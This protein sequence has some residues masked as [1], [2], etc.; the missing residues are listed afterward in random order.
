ME[1]NV[2]TAFIFIFVIMPGFALLTAIFALVRRRRAEKKLFQTGIIYLKKLRIFLMYVQQH[3]GLTSSFFND[4]FALAEEIDQLEHRINEIIV[5]IQRVNGWMQR[6]AKWENLVDHWQRIK[7]YFKNTNAEVN[8]KQHNNLIANLLYLMDDL[9]YAHHLGRLGMVDTTNAK[10]RKLLF[11]AEYVGQARALGVG[12]ASKRHCNSVSRI[13]LH[14]LI[15]KIESNIDPDW[16][17]STQNDFRQLLR[18]IQQ[19]IIV[20]LPSISADDYFKIATS[21]I[22]HLL[23]EFDRQIDKIQFHTG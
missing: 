5:D 7:A 18:I 1:M 22:E 15:L 8:H 10:W 13:Q 4:N 20:E 17:E 6:N 3:R 14:H 12:V 16:P 21:C 2:P 11:I 23:L 19:Q 9:A